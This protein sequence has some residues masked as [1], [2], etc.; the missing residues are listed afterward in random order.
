MTGVALH[1]DHQ[2]LVIDVRHQEGTAVG[3]GKGT[4]DPRPEWRVLPLDAVEGQQAYLHP[5][6]PLG[7]GEIDDARQLRPVEPAG[8]GLEMAGAVHQP[9]PSQAHSPTN[10]VR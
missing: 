5:V 2:H 8:S 9:S 7:V 4:D 10:S 3:A 6:A 1:E